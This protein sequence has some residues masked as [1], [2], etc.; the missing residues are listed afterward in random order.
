MADAMLYGDETWQGL[1]V[2]ERPSF[3][4]LA[5]GDLAEVSPYAK[6]GGELIGRDPRE[7]PKEILAKYF[8]VEAGGAGNGNVVR[9]K[10][11][12]CC[13]GQESEVRKCTAFGCSLWPYRMGS[14]PFTNR[15]GRWQP[16][17]PSDQAS[18]AQS[19]IARHQG[20]GEP[21]AAASSLLNAN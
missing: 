10:C 14:N 21:V 12:D 15:K 19:T 5:K 4:D 13:C 18:D 16:Q 3:Y 6:D 7:V 1:P 8:R 11:L 20:S 9:A 2:S 17:T